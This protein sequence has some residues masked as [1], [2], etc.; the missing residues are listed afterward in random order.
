[1]FLDLRHFYRAGLVQGTK[2]APSRHLMTG[3]CSVF[4]L[5]HNTVVS[6]EIF[7]GIG[8][9]HDA[10]LRLEHLLHRRRCLGIRSCGSQAE[11]GHT[12]T[13]SQPAEGAVSPPR[14]FLSWAV[15]EQAVGFLLWAQRPSCHHT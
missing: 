14:S 2:A 11:V 5:G 15:S 9:G 10:T 8:F 12:P 6:T 3:H 13:V 4:I 7:I 1:M